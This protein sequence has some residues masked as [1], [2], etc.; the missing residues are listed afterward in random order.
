MNYRIYTISD[1]IVTNEFAIPEARTSEFDAYIVSVPEGH[2]IE[3][4]LNTFGALQIS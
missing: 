4:F 1:G 3:E 2:N